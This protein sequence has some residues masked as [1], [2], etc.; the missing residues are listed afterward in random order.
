MPTSRQSRS[1]ATDLYDALNTALET[2]YGRIRR[3]IPN[4]GSALSARLHTRFERL[5]GSLHQC[6]IAALYENGIMDPS[7]YLAAESKGAN[8]VHRSC[9]YADE[10]FQDPDFSALVSEDARTLLG[11]MLAGIVKS[12]NGKERIW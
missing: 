7:A 6:W 12:I 4:D 8:A 11:S 10:C 3:I 2:I 1:A 9:E 5:H